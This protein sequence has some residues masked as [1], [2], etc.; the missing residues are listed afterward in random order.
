MTG[1]GQRELVGPGAGRGRRP[2]GSGPRRW[3]AAAWASG[4]V[5]IRWEPLGGLRRRG[6]GDRP[7]CLAGQPGPS[8][9]SEAA[10]RIGTHARP[11]PDRPRGRR[12]RGARVR[13]C[14]GDLRGRNGCSPPTSSSRPR[15]GTGRW[16]GGWRPAWPARPRRSPTACCGPARCWS[17]ARTRPSPGP[18]RPGSPVLFDRLDDETAERLGRRP[19]G[20]ELTSGYSVVPGRAADR[21]RRG[22]GLR[23]VR[24]GARQPGRSGPADIALAG[25][26]ASRAAVCIDNA[27]L[28]HRERRTA[29]ALQRGLLPGRAARPGGHGG[30]APA[31]CRS[32]TA[33]SAATG[34]TS[35]PLPGGRAAL[36]VGDAMGHGPE[37]A[38][39]M[40][41]LRTAAHT[42]AGLDLPPERGAGQAGHDGAGMPAAPFATC[43]YAVIDPAGQHVRDRPGRAPAAGAGAAGR[44]DRGA[45]PA[46]RVSRSG[47]APSPSRRPRSACRPGP[48]SPCTPTG[49]WKAAPGRSTTASPRCATRSAPPWPGPARLAG[50]RLRDGNPGRCASTARTTSRSSWPA[51]GSDAARHPGRRLNPAISNGDSPARPVPDG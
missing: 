2:G 30:R 20:R 15:P 18:W 12:R 42:L 23:D 40:V 41:Q 29:F 21:P 10:A 47:S 6:A 26:L 48:P 27:R 22:G 5:A 31:T 45:R 50:Q 1:P 13:R 16:C 36:I 51:S 46:R 19:G 49:W 43:I 44:R 9:L 17:S 33:W 11:D 25:E 38:A 24:A 28:Y 32:A 39:V 8:W 34:M 3:R 37:A 14:R 4:P 35:S 7:A